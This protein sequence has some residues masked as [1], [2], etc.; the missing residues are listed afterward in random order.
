MKSTLLIFIF[1]IFKIKFN[2]CQQYENFSIDD[3]IKRINEENKDTNYDN[4]KSLIINNIKDYYIYLDIAKEPP[5]NNIPKID[6][7][8]KLNDINTKNI[9]YYEFFSKISLSISSVLDLNLIIQFGKLFKYLYLLPFNFQVLEKNEKYYLYYLVTG[10][11]I[12]YDKDL[13]NKIIL[14][15]K[16]I[17]IKINDKD[18]F[19]YIEE[20]AGNIYK[21]K[22]AQYTLNFMQVCG[23]KLGKY[24][25]NSTTFNN[26]KIEFDDKTI[27]TIDYKIVVAKK[28]SND[29]INNFTFPYNNDNLYFFDKENNVKNNMNGVDWD[30][31]YNN[32]IKYKY[33]KENKVNVIYQNSFNFMNTLSIDFSETIFKFFYNISE[34]INVNDEPII[35]IESLNSGGQLYFSSLLKKVLNHKIINTKNRLSINGNDKKK[36]KN[37]TYYDTETCKLK[38]DLSDIKEDKY[39]NE[40]IHKRTKIYSE[41]NYY[42][43]E[44][45][46]EN[47]KKKERKPTDIIIFTDAFSNGVTSFFIKDLQ[48]TGNAIIVGYNGNPSDNKKND[49]FDSSQSPSEMKIIYDKESQIYLQIP[50]VESFNDSYKHSS[51]IIP[52]EYIINPIDERSKI[53]TFYGDN[54]YSLFINE[55][56]RIFNKYKKECNKDNKKLLLLNDKCKF[57]DKN[58]KGG[59]IC[60]DNGTWSNSNCSVS[61][62]VEGYILDSFNQTC[63]PDLCWKNGKFKD[64]VFTFLFV[65]SIIILVLLV[66][67][68]F[69]VLFLK[70]MTGEKNKY[71][72]IE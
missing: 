52:R 37:I 67:F 72:L 55:A 61:Y 23:G 48:E 42:L 18:P 40:I 6:L 35:V 54:K 33:D 4:L 29:Y 46:L 39:S 62:C 64:G 14:G 30:F 70:L 9:Q 24:P 13:Q 41:T 57:N 19:D 25:F 58:A 11:Y 53:Y 51:N 17:I 65:V 36:L 22:H 28:N 10:N 5:I 68:F 50:Y 34:K 16:K 45:L 32:L 21:N 63:V 7:I 2:N 26:I 43:I 66:I 31:N 20:F 56:K 59:F 69:Y 38:E 8:S 1:L 60:N 71:Q 44:K 47:I 49:K 15:H 12:F 27:L 3:A